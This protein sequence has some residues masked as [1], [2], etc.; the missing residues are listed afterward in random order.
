MLSGPS[1]P[2]R[3]RR[4]LRIAIAA[5]ALAAIPLAGLVVVALPR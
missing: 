4:R 2:S 3:R 5:V 1:T